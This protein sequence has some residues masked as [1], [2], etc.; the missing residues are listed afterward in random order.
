MGIRVLGHLL[1]FMLGLMMD[2]CLFGWV[3]LL[4]FTHSI[5]IFLFFRRT[6]LTFSDFLSPPL[7]LY[8]L[9]FFYFPLSLLLLSVSFCILTFFIKALYLFLTFIVEFLSLSS[10]KQ[11][12]H[13]GNPSS[14]SHTPPKTIIF[15]LAFS[16]VCPNYRSFSLS[17]FYFYCSFA[18]NVD[19]I[20]VQPY[21]TRWNTPKTWIHLLFPCAFCSLFSNLIFFSFSS[22][23]FFFNI[24]FL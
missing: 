22:L 10:C 11:T 4:T 3:S 24:S 17:H 21:F 5:L 6:D 2:W 1:F 14:Q 19:P 8:I 13:P 23:S 20:E 9:F 18:L 15:E 12:G 7:S 16:A